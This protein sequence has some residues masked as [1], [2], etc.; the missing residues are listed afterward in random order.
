PDAQKQPPTPEMPDN[1]RL[2][3]RPVLRPGEG[4]PGKDRRREPNFKP[5]RSQEEMGVGDRLA[6][7]VSP[8]TISPATVSPATVSPATVSPA[9]ARP[10]TIGPATAGSPTGG[11]G[12][13]TR[14]LEPTPIEPQTSRGVRHRRRGAG[15]GPAAGPGYRRH[16]AWM[17][18]LTVLLLL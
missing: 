2:L 3:F 6:A 5:I 10:P 13:G 16:L 12:T 17:A 7:T 14:V 8:A 15:L 4:R 18:G 11:R 1:V 9:T